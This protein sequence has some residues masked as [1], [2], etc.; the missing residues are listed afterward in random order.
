MKAKTMKK[1]QGAIS[2]FLVIVLFTTSLMGGLFIDATRIL[3]AKRAIRNTADSAARSALS[4]YDGDISTGYG[5]FGVTKEDAEKA[6][7]HYFS[8][9]IKLSQNDGFNILQM[10]P[11]E[12]RTTFSE[13]DVL[14]NCMVDGMTDY[15]K[16]RA[17]VDTSVGITEK[18]K[19]LFSAGSKAINATAKGQDA[20][21][22][23]KNDAQKFST[24]ARNLISTAIS[25]QTAR[26]KTA[27][28]NIMCDP[29]GATDD[30]S[31]GF[32][33]MNDSLD[34][35]AQEN[36]QFAESINS[37]R[38]TTRKAS[39][40]LNG[41]EIGSACYY[42][43]TSKTWKT[44]AGGGNEDEE[45]RGTL[46]SVNSF[47]NS[48]N[49]EKKAVDQKIEETRRNLESKK[50]EIKKKTKESQQLSS[51]IIALEEVKNTQ[52]VLVNRLQDQLNELKR[53]KKANRFAFIFGDDSDLDLVNQVTEY[54]TKLDE[55]EVLKADGASQ[56]E[57]GTK[58]R[59]I[60]ELGSKIDK[61]VAGMENPPKTKYDDEIDKKKNEKKTAE[62][63][64]NATKDKIESKKAERDTLIRDVKKLYDQ[65]PADKTAAGE[66]KT[67]QELDSEHSE[68]AASNLAGFVGDM[69]KAYEKYT[70]ELTK[71]DRDNPSKPD[72]EGSAEFSM[73]TDLGADVWGMVD[74]IR[75]I[76]D[77]LCTAITD[78]EKLG[79]AYL[80]T[81][82]AF[83]KFSFLT[84]Q[85]GWSSHYFQLGEIEYI[86][87][88]AS[89]QAKNI[90]STVMKIFML[91][92]TINFI[93]YMV[94]THS[95][96]IISRT[97][98]ALGRALIQSIT[99]MGEMV[100]TL[101]RDKN[102][103][104]QLCPAFKKVRLTYSDHLKLR[105]L[106]DNIGA[107]GRERSLSRM[108]KMIDMSCEFNGWHKPS[109]LYTRVDGEV[110]VKVDLVML[111]LPMFEAVLPK[112]NKILQDGCFIVHE[113]VNM[114]Y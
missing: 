92:L 29:N 19:G 43:E 20:M 22:Q 96:E 73:K 66:L 37:Y 42:D 21:T 75:I 77:G 7:E 82:Y 2:I 40:E 24:N 14:S 1:A 81:D 104:C 32:D 39:E 71:T 33:E 58:E 94:K 99:D 27:V 74:D 67:P 105:Y 86:L 28:E 23:L 17:L 61:Y 93:Y 34:R 89:S 9:N 108:E 101:D 72:G 62:A 102:A 57:I 70:E 15:A 41:V 109:T 13:S 90:E 83:S 69:C 95:P 49:E 64:L 56:E 5:L 50:A 100:F 91:R 111:T 38:E 46:D 36:E 79:E 10:Q 16:Y 18:I 87:D 110:S 52:Q 114:G 6:F 76:F 59:E 113:T 78:P 3:L 4:Y 8:T 68:R 103:S 54:N 48:A 45:D 97:I 44:E 53:N 51:E 25:S 106:L 84:S 30:S 60:E 107:D 63:A 31:L 35:A 80:M 12:V 65:I 26:A 98:I 85:T 47:E 112:E 55:L 11:L 88:G